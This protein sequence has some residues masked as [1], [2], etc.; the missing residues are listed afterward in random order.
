[1]LWMLDDYW[2]YSL[3]TLFMLVTFEC[4][5]VGQRLRNLKVWM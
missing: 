5:T 3:F 1:M 2:Y 4:T